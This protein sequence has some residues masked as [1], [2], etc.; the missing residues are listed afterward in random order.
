[1]F[2]FNKAAAEKEGSEMHKEADKD[3]VGLAAKLIICATVIDKG[4][5]AYGDLIGGA[6]AEGWTDKV[7]VVI[8]IDDP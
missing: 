3:L 5:A 8:K 6:I 4:A 7:G 2:Y 1:M